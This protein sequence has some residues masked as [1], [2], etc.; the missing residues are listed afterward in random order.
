MRGKEIGLLFN[1]KFSAFWSFLLPVY[2]A[3]AAVPIKKAAAIAAALK[4]DILLNNCQKDKV[5]NEEC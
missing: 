4:L 5:Q 2:S 3:S 1:E